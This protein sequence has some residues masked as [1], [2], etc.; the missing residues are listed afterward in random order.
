LPSQ[1]TFIPEPLGRAANPSP[2]DAKRLHVLRTLLVRETNVW[3]SLRH[4]LVQV[5]AN[6]QTHSASESVMNNTLYP[7]RGVFLGGNKLDPYN[8]LLEAL[9]DFFCKAGLSLARADILLCNVVQPFAAAIALLESNTMLGKRAQE[10]YETHP[11]LPSN[12]ITR[13]MCTQLLLAREP[14]GSC[15]QQ[16]LHYIYQ[17]TCQAKHCA[18]CMMGRNIL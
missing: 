3:E 10:L 1:N 2:L 12:A 16:G 4:I 15:Q 9:R 7:A 5:C 13:M 11:G 6:E 17:Q 14:R 18:E 8:T